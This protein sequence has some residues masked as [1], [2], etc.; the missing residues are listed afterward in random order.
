MERDIYILFRSGVGLTLRSGGGDVSMLS[1]LV[2]GFNTGVFFCLDDGGVVAF[3]SKS[4]D[5]L[6]GENTR[7]V[8]NAL[9]F[10]RMLLLPKSASSTSP[11][12]LPMTLLA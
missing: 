7:G 1:A 8:C 6:T 11:R 4:I 12:G 2:R 10:G 3:L 5:F 9:L